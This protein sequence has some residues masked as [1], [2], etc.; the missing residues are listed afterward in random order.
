MEMEV[1]ASEGEEGEEEGGGRC[2]HC[3]GN[4]MEMMDGFDGRLSWS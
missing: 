1:G 4:Q 2:V 3:G